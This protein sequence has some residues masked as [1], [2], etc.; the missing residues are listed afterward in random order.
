MLDVH[1]A[2]SASMAG[3]QKTT[4]SRFFK[5]ALGGFVLT[6]Y[7]DEHARRSPDC[8]FFA[9][10]IGPKPTKAGK[11]N[12]SR[13]SKASRMSTQSSFSVASEGASIA[14]ADPHGD[15]LMSIA[16]PT[17]PKKATKG[18]K[19][20]SKVK[21]ENLM[22]KQDESQL[23]SS[24]IEPEDDDFEVKVAQ[25]PAPRIKGQKRTSEEFNGAVEEPS[26]KRRATRTRNSVTNVRRT[27]GKANHEDQ[28]EQDHDIQMTDAENMLPLSKP[29][30]KK[31]GKGGRKRAS[32]TARK[33]ST[34]STAS[35][36]SLRAVMPKDEEI[37]AALEADLDRPL[38]DDGED[39]EVEDI[40][41]AKGRRL[42]RSKPG[43]KATAASTAPTRRTTRTST[44]T[45]DD[46]VTEMYP[47]IPGLHESVEQ[48]IDE[49]EKAEPELK[50]L[51]KQKTG[52]K[53]ATRK[54]SA[55]E[56]AEKEAISVEEPPAAVEEEL[57][58]ARPK[59]TRARQ[60]SRQISGRAGRPSNMFASQFDVDM[61]FNVDSSMLDTQTA[62]DDS[63]HETD[64][65]VPTKGRPKRSGRKASTAKNKKGGKKAGPK[66]RNIEDFVQLSTA[67]LPVAEEQVEAE[68]AVDDTQGAEPAAAARESKKPLK[69]Q[70]NAMKAGTKPTRGKKA[71][72]KAKEEEDGFHADDVTEP[73][74]PTNE[75]EVP[76]SPPAT[77]A[78]S[79]PRQAPS[80]QS[81]DVENQP[82]S[83]RPSQ[84]RPPLSFENPIR[85]QET[86]IPLAVITTPIASPSKGNFSKLHSTF[87]WT[88]M[89]IDE[90]FHGTPN[91][92]KENGPFA[93]GVE[94]L[95]SPEKKLTVEEWIKFNA[96][97]GEEKLRND[98]ERLVGKFEGEGVRALRTLEGIV[99]VD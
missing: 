33:A 9:L 16:E 23:A 20:G 87:P 37:D 61:A 80:P 96:Q 92:D 35:K 22:P 63:G 2:T 90:A 83:S 1:T 95:T 91:G 24:F 89:D 27:T 79:T 97:R 43:S 47:V 21:A 65:T 15:S 29:A 94:A 50:P 73:Q 64:A 72:S 53:K 26:K 12:K 52:K 70:P 69:K 41:P 42:T 18:G 32:S 19:K 86:R 93:S 99:C 39:D 6:Y 81:S 74:G 55:K 8:L 13:A 49:A 7:S 85:S 44:I 59:Q 4:H 68:A 5:A 58:T 14:E 54:A 46:S 77:S 60:R 62:E 78:H 25:P 66:S 84:S 75:R 67:E 38:T 57:E 11:T 31:G 36:A 3:S 40:K 76:S 56:K 51:P 48:P 30:S 82:P 10:S 71:A 17:K 45:V 88:A 98:C 28:A 34:T